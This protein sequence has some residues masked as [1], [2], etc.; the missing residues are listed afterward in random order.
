[1]LLLFDDSEDRFDQ[2]LSLLIGPFGFFG[3]HP[4]PVAEKRSV[5]RAY[6]QGPPM[7][8]VRRTDP[9]G[10]AGPAHGAR[11]AVEPHHGLASALHTG[12]AH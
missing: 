9:E 6:L 8:S 3:G 2:L 11:G 10:R 1:M 12:E 5:V 4:G 7:P